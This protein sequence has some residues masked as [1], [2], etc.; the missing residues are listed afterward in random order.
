MVAEVIEDFQDFIGECKRRPP[1]FIFDGTHLFFNAVACV[2]SCVGDR[3]ARHV[4]ESLCTRQ[5]SKDAISA[6]RLT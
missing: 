2:D 6:R 5:G 4:S 3:K 1:A